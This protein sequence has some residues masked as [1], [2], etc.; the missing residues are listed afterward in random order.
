[1]G[2]MFLGAKSNLAHTIGGIVLLVSIFELLV[3][4][5]MLYLISFVGDVDF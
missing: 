2:L 4:G 5:F 1:M 3:T